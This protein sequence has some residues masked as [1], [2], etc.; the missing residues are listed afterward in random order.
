[1][2]QCMCVGRGDGGDVREIDRLDYEVEGWSVGIVGSAKDK[3]RSVRFGERVER[4]VYEGVKG[5]VR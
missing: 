3:K 2:L 5:L 4:F 1:M